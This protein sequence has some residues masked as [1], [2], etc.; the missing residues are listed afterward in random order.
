LSEGTE[1]YHDLNPE[2]PEYKSGMLKQ[3]L[4]K[5]DTQHLYGYYHEYIS[6]ILIHFKG[7]VESLDRTS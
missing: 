1:K 6:V 3:I 4:M 5:P 7:P 2:P